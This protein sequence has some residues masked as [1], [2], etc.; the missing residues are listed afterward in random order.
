[1]ANVCG[2][3]KGMAEDYTLTE[4]TDTSRTESPFIPVS[5][6][7]ITYGQLKF[8]VIFTWEKLSIEIAMKWMMVSKM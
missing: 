7:V 6:A 1:M 4:Q 5:C 3:L 8:L 2:F